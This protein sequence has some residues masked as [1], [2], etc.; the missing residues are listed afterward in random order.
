MND[1]VARAE[2]SQGS[3]TGGAHGSEPLHSE[4]GL[5]I[6]P[7]LAAA[8]KEWRSRLGVASA[9]LHCLSVASMYDESIDSSSAGVAEV[10]GRLIDETIKQLEPV[11]PS[12]SAA[13]NQLAR[14]P[15]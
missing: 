7:C 4:R 10:A 1:Q 14:A 13:K 15:K 5:D 6:P 3:H 12:R 9:L 8:I 11:E 2:H